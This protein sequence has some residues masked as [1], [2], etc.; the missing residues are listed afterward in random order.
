MITTISIDGPVEQHPKFSSSVQEDLKAKICAPTI[1]KV[2]H[3]VKAV[4]IV[5]RCNY[6]TVKS[7]FDYMFIN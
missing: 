5:F 2:Y 1:A 4:N 7:K 3:C 6:Y